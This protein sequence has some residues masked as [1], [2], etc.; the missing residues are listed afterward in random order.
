MSEKIR[1]IFAEDEESLGLIVKE[2]LETRDFE[3]HHFT[4]GKAALQALESVRPDVAVLDVMM[5]QLD[6]FSVAEKIRKKNKSLPIIFLTSR[7]RTEDLLEGYKKGGNDYLRKPFS[8]EELIV[9]I[10]EL[11]KRNHQAVSNNVI[12]LGRYSF[13][14]TQQKLKHN[15]TEVE[16]THRETLLLKMLSENCNEVVERVDILNSIWGTDDFFSGRSMDVFI[17]KLRKHLSKD[18]TIKILNIRG[19]GYKL[20]IGK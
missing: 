4:D 2:S 7:S 12:S 1:I 11:L 15:N 17:T 19:I 14:T 16:L 3:V 6:G 9:R 5:P 10:K 20:V 13:D 8:M 18:P